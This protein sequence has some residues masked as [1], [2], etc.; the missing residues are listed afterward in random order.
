[1][2][3]LWVTYSFSRFCPPVCVNWCQTSFE[4]NRGMP[5]TSVSHTSPHVMLTVRGTA[6]SSACGGSITVPVQTFAPTT[7]GS[8]HKNRLRTGERLKLDFLVIY[9][10][11][12]RVEI[13]AYD[14]QDARRNI[15]DWTMGFN[16]E[17]ESLIPHP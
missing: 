3:R 9:V 11:C 16:S 8:P 14:K 15:N 1:M 2:S 17:S 5:L 7:G 12:V 6:S 10:F 4:H 13:P